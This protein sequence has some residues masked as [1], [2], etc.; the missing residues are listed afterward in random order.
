MTNSTDEDFGL[1]IG[2]I[3]YITPPKEPLSIEFLQVTQ[4][5]A[6]SITLVPIGKKIT[7]LNYNTSFFL[8]L[9]NEIIGEA[10]NKSRDEFLFLESRKILNYW[11][12]DP[13]KIS[14]N[15]V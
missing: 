13:I 4:S 10:F 7:S 6:N 5:T 1:E 11:N 8:P 15:Y 2:D 3:Y 9:Y 14:F 12:G